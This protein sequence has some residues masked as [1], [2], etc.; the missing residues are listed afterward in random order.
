MTPA[1]PKYSVWSSWA[2]TKALIAT[3]PSPP[4]RFSTTTDLPQRAVKRS[5]NSRAVMSVALAG[6]N[7]NMSRTVRVG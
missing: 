4:G 3:R 6:P 2:S 1:G 7:G 5:A